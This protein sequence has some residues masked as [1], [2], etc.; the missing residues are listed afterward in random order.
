M[1]PDFRDA[2]SRF[3]GELEAM[4]NQHGDFSDR[5]KLFLAD[6]WIRLAQHCIAYLEEIQAEERK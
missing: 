3:L 2:W 6:L 1:N 5:H 4:R